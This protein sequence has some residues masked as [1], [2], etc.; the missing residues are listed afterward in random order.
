MLPLILLSSSPAY[1]N[2]FQITAGMSVTWNADAKHH[3][4]FSVEGTGQYAVGTPNQ[5]ERLP[6]LGTLVGGRFGD[7]CCRRFVAGVLAGEMWYAIPRLGVAHY[8]L[9]STQVLMAL[10]LGTV[11]P[12]AITLGALV[13]GG[14]VL[15]AGFEIDRDLGAPEWRN[16]TAHLGLQVPLHNPVEGR[17]L[18]TSTGHA[19]P[20]VLHPPDADARWIAAGKNEFAS[21]AAFLRLSSELRVLG[22]PHDLTARARQAARDEVAHARLSFGLAGGAIVANSLNAR[23]RSFMSREHARRVIGSESWVDG[24][25][26]EGESARHAANVRDETRD[27]TTARVMH[28]IA[29]DEQRHAELGRDIAIYCESAPPTTQRREFGEG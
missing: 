20:T 8:D 18:R 27:E 29:V 19:L 23:P 12:P 16:P 9:F 28:R 24:W 3:I 26:G 2:S 5:S 25:L 10:S 1:A 11:Q 6:T 4:G 7:P 22:A 13:T 14:Q 17:P 15:H 21:I